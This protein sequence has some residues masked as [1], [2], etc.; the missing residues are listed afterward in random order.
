MKP[1]LLIDR[2]VFTSDEPP[3]RRER[4]EARYVDADGN[5]FSEEGDTSASALSKLYGSVEQEGIN[6]STLPPPRKGETYYV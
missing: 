4:F 6:R 3:H 5:R 1:K 2:Y